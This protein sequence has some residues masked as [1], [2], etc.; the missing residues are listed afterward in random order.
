MKDGRYETSKEQVLDFERSVNEGEMM[1]VR[2]ALRLA[3]IRGACKE[4]SRTLRILR[5]KFDQQVIA[6]EIIA[7]SVNEVLGFEKA[8]RPRK[9]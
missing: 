9:A 7:Q 1:T 4:R 8:E 6:D 2:E 5:E 3:M